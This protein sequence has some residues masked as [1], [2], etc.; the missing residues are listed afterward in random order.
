MLRLWVSRMNPLSGASRSLWP[1]LAASN[2]WFRFSAPLQRTVPRTCRAD[3]DGVCSV[4][5]VRD[6]VATPLRS[7]GCNQPRSPG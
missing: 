1:L 5:E 7:P 6:D 2:L 3:G 4:V